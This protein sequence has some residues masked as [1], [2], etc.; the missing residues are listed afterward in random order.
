MNS[1]MS[2]QTAVN[3]VISWARN[4]AQRLM[5]PHG[6]AVVADGGDG[7]RGK[8]IAG[9]GVGESGGSDSSEVAG[10]A[11]G[12]S[13][14]SGGGSLNGGIFDSGTSPLFPIVWCCRGA[15]GRDSI[16]FGGRIITIIIITYGER[17]RFSGSC[18]MEVTLMWFV[19]NIGGLMCAYYSG[20]FNTLC[21]V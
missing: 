16:A 3:F 7:S 5:K 13:G 15:R 18:V 17:M 12:G 14:I 1:S 8:G 21:R 2:A 20:T 19:D 10:N 11:S 4:L 6:S 9:C